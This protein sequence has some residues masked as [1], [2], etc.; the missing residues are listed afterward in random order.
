MAAIA[1]TTFLHSHDDM[2]YHHLRTYDVYTHPPH[3]LT[4]SKYQLFNVHVSVH[5]QW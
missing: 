2:Y 3:L 4:C 1:G 5:V